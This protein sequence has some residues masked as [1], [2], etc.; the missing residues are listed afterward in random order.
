MYVFMYVKIY[1][2]SPSQSRKKEMSSIL[3]KKNESKNRKCHVISLY[4]KLNLSRVYDGHN[5]N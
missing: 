4:S 2:L 5:N 3:V 1:S